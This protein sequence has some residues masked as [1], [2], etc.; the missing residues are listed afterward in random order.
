M[1]ILHGGSIFSD[2]D[3]VCTR[4]VSTCKTRHPRA[5]NDPA[6]DSDDPPMFL[7]PL[8]DIKTSF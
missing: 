5:L 1:A 8:H 7:I 2:A 6:L 3:N 4:V